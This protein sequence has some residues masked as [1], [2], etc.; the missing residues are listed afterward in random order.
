[1][2][3]ITFLFILFFFHTDFLFCQNKYWQQQVNYTIHATLNDATNTL[4]GNI[5]IDYFNNSPDTLEF[6]WIHLWPNAFKNDYT[7]YSEYLLHHGRNDFYF[8]DEEQNGYINRLAFT[9]NGTVS[10]TQEIPA[11]QDIIKLM[12]PQPLLPKSNIKIETPFH[13][14]LPFDFSGNGYEKKSYQVTEWYPQPAVYD[15]KGWHEMPY[16]PQ[17]NNYTEFGNFDVTLTLPKNYIIAAS[18]KLINETTNET[19]NKTWHFQQ[20]NINAFTWFADKKFKVIQTKIATPGGKEI[21]ASIYYLSKDSVW[22]SLLKQLNKSILNNCS[23]FGEYPY[24]SISVVENVCRFNNTASYPMMALIKDLSN[25]PFTEAALARAINY[26]WFGAAVDGNPREHTWMNEGTNSFFLNQYLQQDS[27]TALSLM[28]SNQKWIKKRLPDEPAN[29]ILRTQITTKQI[30]PMDTKTDSLTVVND[31]LITHNYTSQ[32]MESMKNKIGENAFMK[33]IREYYTE[34]KFKHPYPE[35]LKRIFAKNSNQNIDSNFNSIY[36]T[37]SLENRPKKIKFTTLFDLKEMDK[38]RYLSIGPAIGYNEYDGLMAG[39]FI[40]NYSLPPSKFQF[41]VAAMY[42]TNSNRLN[43]IGKLNYSWY[44]GNMLQK[45]ECSLSGYSFSVNNYQD[46]SGHTTYLNASKIVPSVLI[47]FRNKNRQST[48]VKYIQW[49]TFF[50]SERSLLFTRD[51]VTQNFN[52]S[53]P[54]YYRYVNQLRFVVKD[55]RMLYPYN[56]EI[57]AEQGDGFARTTFTGNYFFNYRKEGGL[58]VRFFFGK[59]FH[60]AND[61]NDQYFLDLTGPRGG[62]DYTYSNYFLGR[63]QFQGLASQQLMERDGFFKIGTDLLSPKVG[64]TDNWLTAF[65]FTTTIPKTI[66]PLQ[67]LPIPI[68]LKAFLDIG[69]NGKSSLD[70]MNTSSS[71]QVLY[72]A[73]LQVSLFKNVLNIYVPLF[74][75]DVYRNYFQSYVTGNRFEKSISFSIDFQQICNPK[76]QS[77]FPL[78]FL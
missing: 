11:S 51:T 4:D 40:H 34:W 68:P 9:V 70:Y 13:I 37:P 6:I 28:K 26:Q 3:Q 56:A 24:S 47:V 73:G 21:N 54:T 27:I 65:N 30:Q 15:S 61:Y 71:I 43:G 44:P 19:G 29:L 45:I 33:S 36:Q 76:I 59:Y 20:Q 12:L 64:K 32:W 46:S 77:Y 75:S 62:E 74:Y 23:E 60:K 58:N 25:K 55:A 67:A 52:I 10:E 72:D 35:D 5:Q 1:M 78:L 48:I 38:Y 16:L 50:I 17:H 39:A 14:R 66:N 53:Y 2:K 57:D 42:G 18:G 8:T 22:K 63:N 7:D 69:T 41:F 31:F 49:K